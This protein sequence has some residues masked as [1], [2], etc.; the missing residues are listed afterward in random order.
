MKKIFFASDLHLGSPNNKESLK[1][2]KHFV[3]WL[4]S[5]K[6]EAEA[7]YLLG[8]IFDFWF[9]YNKVV[10]KGFTRLLGKLSE[11]TDYGIDIYFFT[12]NHDMWT[13]TYFKNEIGIKK[14][15]QKPIKIKLNGKLFFLGHG[16]GIGNGDFF[17][18][19]LK[20]LFKS[21]ICQF[22]F[23]LIH[24]NIGISIAQFWSKKS[25]ESK[26]G[27]MEK[28]ENL[29]NFCYQKMEKDKIDYF[30][31]GHKHKDEK[32]KIGKNTFYINLGDWISL[33]SYAV[34]D[35]K[36]IDLKYFN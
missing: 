24:P 28:H 20:S 23:S 22:F 30:I 19:I 18:K 35:G 34:F 10:P 21:S 1:R 11:L 16:D 17:F 12:G 29:I 13:Y 9:E 14:I 6:N 25:R 5:I 31:F 32:I 7:I 27:S 26:E 8:D 3:K 2:E 15:Y 33:N 36:E 4:N